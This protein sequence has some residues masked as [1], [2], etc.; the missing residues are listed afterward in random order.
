M[1]RAALAA[2]ATT[3]TVVLAAILV[4]LRAMA[5]TAL[6][7]RQAR[8]WLRPGPVAVAEE[9]IVQPCDRAPLV[10]GMA[11][12]RAVLEARTTQ[13]ELGHAA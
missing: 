9:K 11:E 5:A 1:R 6:H 3:D 8:M 7:G 10:G 4:T 12:V 2:L 13:A